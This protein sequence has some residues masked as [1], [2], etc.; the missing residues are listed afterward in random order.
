M[1]SHLPPLGA[2]RQASSL[3]PCQGHLPLLPTQSSTQPGQ[4]V[5]RQGAGGKGGGGPSPHP[6][7]GKGGAGGNS[8]IDFPL[9]RSCPESDGGGGQYSTAFQ[10]SRNRRTHPPKD[11]LSWSPQP[12]GKVLTVCTLADS[13]LSNRE[14][15]T[16]TPPTSAQLADFSKSSN[17]PDTT[18]LGLSHSSPTLSPPGAGPH[19]SKGLFF[20][21]SSL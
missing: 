11:S 1:S 10:K 17:C 4:R 5:P 13:S 16:P 12:A 21:P 9:S 14:A 3:H 7:P 8:C 15:P 2:R 18:F 20:T 6:L 19:P